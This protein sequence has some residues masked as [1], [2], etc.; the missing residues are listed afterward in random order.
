MSVNQIKA[1]T[2]KEKNVPNAN[3]AL[4]LS[5]HWSLGFHLM[6]LSEE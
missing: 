6:T 3:K 1:V 4:G 5:L 2:F